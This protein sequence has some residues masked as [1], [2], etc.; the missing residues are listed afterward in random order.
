MPHKWQPA[1]NPGRILYVTKRQR[2]KAKEQAYTRYTDCSRF[3]LFQKHRVL[4]AYDAF[5]DKSGDGTCEYKIDRDRIADLR[6][7]A[8]VELSC[9]EC[10][11]KEGADP[12]Q[13]DSPRTA[14]AIPPQEFLVLYC[15]E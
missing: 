2:G 14:K 11:G 15:E 4:L 6:G 12:H 5:K 9:R 13:D 3:R 10:D 1:S 7:L 8:S